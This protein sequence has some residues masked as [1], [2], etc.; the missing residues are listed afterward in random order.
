MGVPQFL[1]ADY[2]SALKALLPR[3][4]VW[5][6][7]PASTQQMTLLGLGKT[8]ERC[9]AAAMSILAGSLPGSPLSGFL[10]EWEATLGLPDPCLGS[11]PTFD[12]RFAQV[13]ARFV[14]SGGSSR[15]ALIAFAAAI[16]F[17][18]TVTAYSATSPGPSGHGFTGT[19]WNFVLGIHIVSGTPL[20]VL[21]CALEEIKPAETTIIF[22]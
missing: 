21:Q 17:T 14:A 1:A 20:T 11:S 16:G 10:P 4:R 2:A 7:D 18:I 8:F 13:A 22:I 9:D 12:Q 5:P 19:Q 6:D 15:A 3:G